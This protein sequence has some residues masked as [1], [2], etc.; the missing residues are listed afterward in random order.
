MLPGHGDVPTQL[1]NFCLEVTDMLSVRNFGSRMI[2]FAVLAGLLAIPLVVNGQVTTATIVG[3]ITD[4]GGA[5]VSNAE[6][7][8][9]HQETGLARTVTANDVGA[10]RIEFLPVGKY[11]IDV[12]YTGF[13]R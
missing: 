4:P 13:K 2:Q 10:Y 9:R 1:A 8:A 7:T 12:S 3:T 6:V 5:N 11:T